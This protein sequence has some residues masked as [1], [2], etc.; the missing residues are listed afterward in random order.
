MPKNINHP[1]SLQIKDG[2]ALFHM[3]KDLQ[4]ENETGYFQ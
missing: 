3:A 4:N 2:C 1:L